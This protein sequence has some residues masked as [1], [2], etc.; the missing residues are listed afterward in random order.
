[1][2]MSIDEIKNST[3]LKDLE[4]IRNKAKERKKECLHP[5]SST[6]PRLGF[7]FWTPDPCEMCAIVRVGGGSNHNCG[8]PICSVNH[9]P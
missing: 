4:A 3:D 7:L 8:G 1:M 9:V 5:E 2:V 6:A